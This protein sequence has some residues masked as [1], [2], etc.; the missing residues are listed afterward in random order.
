MPTVISIACCGCQKEERVSVLDANESPLSTLHGWVSIHPIAA[1]TIGMLPMGTQIDFTDALCDQCVA[2]LPPN[3]AERVRDLQA[4]YDKLI[5]AREIVGHGMLRMPPSTPPMGARHR[6]QHVKPLPKPTTTAETDPRL[7]VA[8][9]IFGC[10]ATKAE[11]IS[12]GHRAGCK[13]NDIEN[14][15]KK[16]FKPE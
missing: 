16:L 3:V 12:N 14:R 11:L 5:S 10:G 2:L 6:A 1:T 9:C 8:T 7:L 15:A 13:G 4:Q